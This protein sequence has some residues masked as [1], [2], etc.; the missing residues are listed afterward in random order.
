MKGSISGSLSSGMDKLLLLP[1]PRDW[2]GHIFELALYIGLYLVYLLSRGLV[3]PDASEALRNAERIISLEK[4]LGLFWE[5]AWQTWAIENAKALVI[6]LNWAY[7]VTYFPM[8]LA[9][10]LVLYIVN[11]R[12]Y[13]YYR[14]VIVINLIFA[15]LIFTLF[16]VAP[17][18]KVLAYFLDT[19]QSFGPSFY[20]GPEVAAYR[21]TDAAMPSQHFSWT[22]ILGVL[23]LRTLKG[24]FKLLGFIY[25]TMTFFAIT[26]TGN[27]YILDAIVG[28]ITAVVS[29]AIVELE[30]RHGLFLRRWWPRSGSRPV[31]G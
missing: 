12:L 23:Y 6:F 18:L 28:G 7:I 3:F 4:S 19:I 11:R 2:W 21:N 26:I 10:A 8:I 31:S 1:V 22:V 16:P 24:K 20:G 30:I 13:Y 27:H 15:L 9:L 17:P 29:F 25:P 14:N 5:P